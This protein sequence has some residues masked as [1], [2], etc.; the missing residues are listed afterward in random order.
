MKIEKTVDTYSNLLSDVATEITQ[1]CSD[2]SSVMEI[3][4]GSGLPQLQLELFKPILLENYAF[5]CFFLKDEEIRNRLQVDS[6]DLVDSLELD[7]KTFF[8]TRFEEYAATD[9]RINLYLEYCGFV[10]TSKRNAPDQ[11]TMQKDDLNFFE[12]KTLLTLQ[13]SARK[14]QETAESV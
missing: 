1:N 8:Q 12:N 7:A 9:D 13:L 10:I 4:L 14:M 6:E 2:R 5:F 11:K 3:Y